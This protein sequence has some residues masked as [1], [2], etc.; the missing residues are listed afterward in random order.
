MVVDENNITGSIFKVAVPAVVEQLLIM[1][2]GVVSLAFVG[3]LSNEAVTAVG[4]INSLFGFIQVF[5]VAL[6]TG[7]TV[8]IARLIGEGDTKSAKAAIKEC[9]LIGFAAALVFSVILILLAR[10]V[11][12]AF[13]SGAEKVIVDMAAHYFKITLITL[14]LLFTNIIISGSL[15]GS[16]D[17][18]TPMLIANVVNILNIVLSY[19]LI[20]G[21]SIGNLTI[22]KRGITGAA[23][24]VCISRGVGGVL[25]LLVV[26]SRPVLLAFSLKGKLAFDF[27]LLKRILH[28]GIPASME[29]LIMQ[30][31]FLLLQ[32][33][34][35]RMGTEASTVYQIVMSI[36]S[37]CFVPIFGFG[38]SATTIVGQSLG[39]KRIDLAR[40]AGWKT[41]KICLV[42]TVALSSLLFIFAGSLIR[43][44]TSDPAIIA[45]GTGAIRIF[46][47]SQPFVS[48]VTVVSNALRGAG[49]IIYVMLT[50]FV[51][52][53]CFRVFLTFL[54]GL[55]LRVGITAAW[56]AL[57]L[58]FSIRSV[59]YLTRFRKGKWANISI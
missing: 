10:P 1:I 19:V 59:M 40:K 33:V 45:I 38:L 8:I 49:D 21:V 48:I 47:F 28:V 55:E 58:D 4:F 54:L 46:S 56:I 31:G 39:A 6:S 24:A 50:S 13:F 42:I 57:T 5:F 18:K 12:S 32:V 26:L 20:Y 15:R 17:T 30:G 2:V 53:W 41:V 52:I 27:Q 7:C 29:Q 3:H 35:S 25:S 9:V 43:I 11:I 16:G 36:N 22:E 23:I 37:M 14:P 44:Y 34:I 51:G